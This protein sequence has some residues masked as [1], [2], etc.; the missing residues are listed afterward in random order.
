AD[1]SL[2]AFALTRFEIVGINPDDRGAPRIV[3]TPSDPLL[4]PDGPGLP[5]DGGTRT[6]ERDVALSREDAPVITW[7][8]PLIRNGLDL[9]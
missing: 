3:R 1:T 8:P 5:A 4:G 6:F 2:I 9:S 7:D